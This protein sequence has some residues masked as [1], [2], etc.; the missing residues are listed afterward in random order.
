MNQ[1]DE[2][3]QSSL[4]TAK[5]ILDKLIFDKVG[6]E[7]DIKT[8]YSR[9]QNR[10]GF[11]ILI[12]VDVDK[13]NPSSPTYN[14]EYDSYFNDI[15]KKVDSALRYV[16]LQNIFNG[17]L[18]DYW[19]DEFTESQ[20]DDLNVKLYAELENLYNVRNDEI[21]DSETYYWL[22][23]SD[24]ESPYMRVEGLGNPVEVQDEETGEY[25]MFYKCSELADLMLKLYRESPMEW[26]YEDYVC[27]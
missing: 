26:D 1:V 5:M 22:Y 20:I 6:I 19:N 4:Q 27:Q 24:S 14:A 17:I 25:K 12:D 13:C 9:W 11:T 10:W 2:K 16:Q 15:E 3:F 7:Y 21:Q 23:K 18:F 8:E